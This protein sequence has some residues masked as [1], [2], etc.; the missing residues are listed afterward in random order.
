MSNIILNNVINIS[1]VYVLKHLHLRGVSDGTPRPE[2]TIKY[3][4]S[5]KLK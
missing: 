5:C 2:G 3:R 1:L 4:A